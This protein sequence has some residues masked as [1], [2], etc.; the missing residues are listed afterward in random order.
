MEHIVA[1]L[2]ETDIFCLPSVSEGFST[3]ILEAAA[4]N[5]YIVTTARGG[6]REL[7]IND[8][9]GTVI[10]DNRESYLIQALE[11]AIDNPVHRKKA[12]NLTYRRLSGSFTWEVVASQVEKICERG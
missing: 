5:C 3:S 2:E 6:A 1:L 7:L 8:E 9:Y 11:K 10:P 12:V 4:C